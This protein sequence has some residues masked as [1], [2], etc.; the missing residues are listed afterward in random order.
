MYTNSHYGNGFK[1]KRQI[2]EMPGMVIFKY[3]VTFGRDQHKV[4]GILCGTAKKYHIK[5]EA[6]FNQFGYQNVSHVIIFYHL[7]IMIFPLFLL[8]IPAI[9]DV[10]SHRY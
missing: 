9:K 6:C 10:P 5:L 8:K 3:Y 2:L 4:S 7:I 1:G